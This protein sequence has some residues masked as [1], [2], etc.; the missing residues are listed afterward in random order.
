[1]CGG[2]LAGSSERAGVFRTAPT[3][4]NVRPPAG[5]EPGRVTGRKGGCWWDNDQRAGLMGWSG[6][7]CPDLVP[8]N[9]KFDLNGASACGSMEWLRSSK[10][11]MKSPRALHELGS[12][13][14]TCMT[15]CKARVGKRKSSPML[16]QLVTISLGFQRKSKKRAIG[17]VHPGGLQHTLALSGQATRQL[18]V[19]FCAANGIRWGEEIPST[20]RLLTHKL[21]ANPRRPLSDRVPS[22]RH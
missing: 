9:Q 3:A 10:R 19:A 5:A 8:G 4:R 15:H 16:Q 2:H 12:P 7:E 1:M 18:P 14:L 17:Q 11:S 20:K 13:Q 21:A 22:P 6:H